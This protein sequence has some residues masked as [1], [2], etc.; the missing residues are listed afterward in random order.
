MG[1]VKSRWYVGDDGSR[2]HES[3][4]HPSHE[5][6]IVHRRTHQTPVRLRQAKNGS[7]GSIVLDAA[8]LA[9]TH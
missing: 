4:P 5:H 3:P 6:Y 9:R 2:G 8:C 7:P 1:N